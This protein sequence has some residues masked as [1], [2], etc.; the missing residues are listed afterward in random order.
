MKTHCTDSCAVSIQ[1][2][3]YATFI[4]QDRFGNFSVLKL[5]QYSQPQGCD[6]SDLIRGCNDLRNWIMIKWMLPRGT[7]FIS[8][9][10]NC[11]NI[12]TRLWQV[13]KYEHAF[14]ELEAF[15]YNLHVRTMSESSRMITV[16]EAELQWWEHSHIKKTNKSKWDY[17][18]GHTMYSNL[19]SIPKFKMWL[20]AEFSV[21]DFQGYD[22]KKYLCLVL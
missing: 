21:L 22:K 12:I 14:K 19:P 6:Q 2:T 8:K 9:S 20:A 18:T 16:I 17:Q 10:C 13:N 5:L 4:S 3:S 1:L 7:G 15:E 11:N